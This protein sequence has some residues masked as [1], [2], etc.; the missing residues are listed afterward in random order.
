MRT[1]VIQIGNSDDKLNQRDWSAFVKCV[2]LVVNKHVDQIHFEGAS[3]SVAPWQNCCW[4]LSVDKS[5]IDILREQLVSACYLYRQDSLTWL[6][7]DIELVPT[8]VLMTRK[9]PARL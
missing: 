5:N 4:V 7:G 1:V 9:K 3:A 8:K 6:A 2:Q